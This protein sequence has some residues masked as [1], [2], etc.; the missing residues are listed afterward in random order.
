M[1]DDARLLP[2]IRWDVA[3]AKQEDLYFFLEEI[4]KDLDN[5][6]VSVAQHGE[7]I[8][9]SSYSYLGLIG[10]PDIDA[11][12][13]TAI[14][15]YGTGTHGVRL[16]AGSLPIHRQLEAK[17][18]AFKRTKSAVTFSSGYVANV[19]T[20]SALLRRG[21]TV[22]CD[23]LDHASIVDGSLLSHAQF[24][25]YAHN[26][27]DHLD[28]ILK[29]HTGSARTLVVA[30]AV[31]SMDG[32]IVDLPELVRLCRKYGALSMID[33]AH[34]L[35]VLGRTGHGIEEHFSL[36]SE[37][38]DVKMGTLS[39]AIPSAG[40]YVAGSEELCSFLKHEA[41]GFIFSAA[42]PPPA[43]GAALA[44]LE[45]IER[46]PERIERLQANVR[47]FS[48]RLLAASVDILNTQTAIVPVVCGST[49]TAAR[50]ARHCQRRG[51]FVQAIVAPV[52]PEGSARLRA[53]VTARH[54]PEDLDYCADVI[55][56]GA[57]ALGILGSTPSL[58][59][60]RPSKAASGRT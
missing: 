16:L 20:I 41:R 40:G 44:A 28:E 6:R 27:M 57:R 18:A 33:E 14:D 8:M 22:V 46:E 30:D 13:K 60:M 24:V 12:A 58:N 52:V 11:A 59:L 9:L 50:L 35:G 37:A 4:E 43:A 5:A 49:D 26:D 29:R 38:V 25:R 53:T 1:A 31:F 32:D 42:L 7:M 56:E 19:A 15:R 51:I 10:H 2:E 34:S 54:R 55:I 36:D 45:V 48:G 3:G 21:D 47:H 39:K 23:K 17:L